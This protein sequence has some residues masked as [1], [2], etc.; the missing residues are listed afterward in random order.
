MTG[1]INGA[2]AVEFEP[3]LE[4]VMLPGC[5]SCGHKHPA[6]YMPPL[7]NIEV[8]PACHAPAA[9]PGARVVVPAVVTGRTAPVLAARALL[10]AGR[11]LTRFAKRI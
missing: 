8:C 6:A 5:A 2:A 3:S 7:A 4:L 1:A 11:L 10:A 9:I